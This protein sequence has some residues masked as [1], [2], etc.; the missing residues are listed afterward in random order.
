[1]RPRPRAQSHH[2]QKGSVHSTAADTL[3]EAHHPSKL[4]LACVTPTL[5]IPRGM[6]P[7]RVTDMEQCASEAVISNKRCNNHVLFKLATFLSVSQIKIALSCALMLA[8]HTHCVG[9]MALRSRDISS[10]YQIPP[11]FPL[12]GMHSWATSR[13]EFISCHQRV[14]AGFGQ[15][16]VLLS[17]RKHLR[18]CLI[19]LPSR[20]LS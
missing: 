8:F 20:R 3:D 2:H 19:S 18:A 17:D 6:E 14:R 4:S 15:A 10:Y 13:T 16:C 11:P 9:V 12:R 7:G 1:M 5:S